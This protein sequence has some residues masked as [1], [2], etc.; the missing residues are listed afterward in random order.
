MHCELVVPDLFVAGAGNRYPGLELLLARGRRIADG[1]KPQPLERWLHHAFSLEGAAIPAGALSLIA[2]NRDPGSD[3]WLRADPVHLRVMRDHLVVVPAEALAISKPEADAL[4]ASLNEHFSEVMQLHALAPGRWAAR[5]QGRVPDA[6]DVPALHVAGGELS[7]G[8]GREV[9]LTEIQM[10]LH[11]HPVN[12]AREARGEPT[13]N[14]LWL[15]GAG[16]ADKATSRWASVAADEPLAMGLAMLART[17]YRS[18]YPGAAQWLGNAPEHG[19]HLIVLDTLRVPAALRDP[20]QFHE[21]LAM[22]DKDWFAPLVRALRRGRI[23]MVTL[24][25]PDAAQPVSFE[26]IRAD[27]RRFWRLRKP[28]GRYA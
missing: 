16:R 17:R 15:W 19:R 10:L 6:D 11:A 8:R 18:L 20:G 3:A 12:E 4:C 23:G 7:R 2:T 14:S 21:R 22:L 24:H 13:I 9:E 25:V 27:L 26:T 1:S 28:I 5:V